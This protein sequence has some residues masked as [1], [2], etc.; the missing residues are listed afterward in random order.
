LLVRGITGRNDTLVSF[1]ESAENQAAF[2]GQM[3][4]GFAYT[5]Y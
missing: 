4:N 3:E 1:S 5:L 2:I